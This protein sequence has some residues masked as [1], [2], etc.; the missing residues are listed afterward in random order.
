MDETNWRLISEKINELLSKVMK[1]ERLPVHVRLDHDRIYC[2]LLLLF[3]KDLRDW[4]MSKKN[5]FKRETLEAEPNKIVLDK[6][7]K[8]ADDRCLIL[9]RTSHIPLLWLGNIDQMKE[10]LCDQAMSTSMETIIDYV[11]DEGLENITVDYVEQIRHESQMKFLAEV[12]GG[13][14]VNST[15]D[16]STTTTTANTACY[17]DK[18]F[19]YYVKEMG[20]LDSLLHNIA[21]SIYS[22]IKACQPSI[23]RPIS[24]GTQF[25]I[26]CVKFFKDLLPASRTTVDEEREKEIRKE[27]EKEM[28]EEN[29]VN[30]NIVDGLM[31]WFLASKSKGNAST[32]VVRCRQLVKNMIT[33]KSSL[34]NRKV[35][36]RLGLRRDKCFRIADDVE[37]TNDVERMENLRLDPDDNENELYPTSDSEPEDEDEDEDEQNNENKDGK[38]DEDENEE[39]EQVQSNVNAV[40]SSVKRRRQYKN[41]R[42]LRVAEMHWHKVCIENTFSKPVGV[43]TLE[44][45]R[46]LHKT[47]TQVMLVEECYDDFIRSEEYNQFLETG[48]R[49]IGRQLYE[50]AKCPCIVSLKWHDCADETLTFTYSDL[51]HHI[52]LRH[53]TK[54]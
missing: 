47:H 5:A 31:E 14:N 54:C 50:R 53:S 2:N 15:D 12:K 8:K 1:D 49:S 37:H 27:I 45:S 39:E 44:G 52:W 28:D 42:D 4:F 19:G 13:E 9:Y 43:I 23:H 41:K 6:K 33:S 17:S 26:K 21:T 20:I 35:A 38:E 7:M 3:G 40:F 11:Y 16:T 10:S 34:S 24:L 30:K 22:F 46:E 36:A 32:E 18:R 48:G 51:T 29:N 25:F